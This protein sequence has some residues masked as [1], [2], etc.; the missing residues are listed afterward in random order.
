MT[1]NITFNNDNKNE[2]TFFSRKAFI[3]ILNILLLLF[4]YNP[5][6]KGV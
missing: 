4:T 6:T 2:N 1:S 3:L 5:N